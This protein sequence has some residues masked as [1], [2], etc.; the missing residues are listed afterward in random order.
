MFAVIKTGGKQH[1]VTN[2]SIISVEKLEGAEGSKVEFKDIF[3]IKENS[4]V[5]FVGMPIVKGAKVV[6]EI[7]SHFRAEKIIVFKKKRRHNYRRTN[8]HKQKLT[9]VKIIEVSKE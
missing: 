7:M 6:G 4:A 5:A 9:E 3:M 8:G 2:G 1:T